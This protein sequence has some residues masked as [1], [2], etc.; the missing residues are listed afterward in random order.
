MNTESLGSQA[1]ARW[2][3]DPIAFS[4]DILRTRLWV[5]QADIL[6]AARD[7]RRVAIRSGH[8]CGKTT[9]LACLALWWVCTRPRARVIMTAASYRQVAS[10]LWREVRRLHRGARVPLGGDMHESAESGLQF[11]SGAEII[12]FSTKEPERMA[13]FSGP[14]MLFLVDEASGV[15]DVIFE[16]IEGNRAGGARVVMISNPTQTSGVFYDAFTSER[17]G[18]QCIHISSEECAERATI[19]VGENTGLATFDWVEEKRREWGED[20]PR[21]QVRVRGNFPTQAEDAMVPL[22]IVESAMRRWTS[23]PST[24]GRTQIGVDVARFGTD[25]T[26]IVWSRG[27]WASAPTLVK[28]LDAVD[29]AGRVMQLAGEVA[30]NDEDPSVRV[31][32]TGTGAGVADV[33]RR[34]NG[35]ELVEVDAASSSTVEGFARMGDQMWGSLKEWLRKGGAMPRDARTVAD[36][37]APKYG[38]DV[39]GQLKVERK[40]ELRKRLGRSTD[41]ADAL[42]LS[43]FADADREWD[44]VIVPG[45]YGRR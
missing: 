20:D 39:R 13:R 10:V 17:S 32:V 12:G 35:I 26:A 44:P 22:A 7:H 16:A 37:C 4:L 11:K 6:L 25:S 2:H 23:E 24:V 34:A 40:I 15:P 5:R 9:A 18:W 14:D 43:V 42:A 31:D 45:S 36:V 3:S 21:F 28:G 1:L 33:L 8:K 29:V 27:S 30:V 19:E 38:F 41:R